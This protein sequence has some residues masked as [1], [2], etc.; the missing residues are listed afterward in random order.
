MWKEPILHSMY[1]GN[2]YIIRIKAEDRSG[3]ILAVSRGI[4]IKWT[5]VANEQ[6][7]EFWK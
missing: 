1:I 6:K 3:G 2:N 5:N 4:K 7:P